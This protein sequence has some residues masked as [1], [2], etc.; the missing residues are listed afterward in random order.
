MKAPRP[1]ALDSIAGTRRPE[2]NHCWC[3]GAPGTPGS[4]RP[5]I[6]LTGNL[7]LRCWRG[8]PRARTTWTRATSALRIALDLPR[9]WD[10][11]FRVGWVENAALRHQVTAWCDVPRNLSVPLP[12]RPFDWISPDTLAAAR[13]DL[14]AREADFDRSRALPAVRLRPGRVRQPAG[15]ET[16]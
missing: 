10:G 14:T 11:G 15:D 1:R 2:H 5:D 13:A 6:H 9:V 12:A 4:L 16:S 7:C 8:Q 3:C